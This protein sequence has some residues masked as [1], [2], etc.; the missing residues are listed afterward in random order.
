M[1]ETTLYHTWGVVAGQTDLGQ[2]TSV[3]WG[4]KKNGYDHLERFREY[5]EAEEGRTGEP[6]ELFVLFANEPD[7]PD[8]ADLTTEEVARLFLALVEICPG[9]RF[10]GPM[11]SAADAG[12]MVREVWDIV[13]EICGEPCP[14]MDSLYA[15]SLHVYPR[16]LLNYGP[17]GRVDDFCELV[18]G[19]DC[20]RPVWITEFGYRN[21]Y[22]GTRKVFSHWIREAEQDPRI[23]YYFVYSTYQQPQIDCYFTPLLEWESWE[24]GPVLD[25]MGLAWRGVAAE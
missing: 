25:E 22:G 1:P 19:G 13:L 5:I 14:A 18:D 2:K 11:Y 3:V 10:V 15:H 21:C 9:C 20:L 4:W 24:T 16:P 23:E 6:A 12:Q 8:Q 17:I 7:R